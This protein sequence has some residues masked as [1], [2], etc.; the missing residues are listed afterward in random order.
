M[1]SFLG[2]MNDQGDEKKNVIFSMSKAFYKTPD[3]FVYIIYSFIYL[4]N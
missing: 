4:L 2:K 3:I 1:L